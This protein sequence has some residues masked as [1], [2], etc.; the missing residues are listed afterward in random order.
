MT[1]QS[2]DAAC[3]PVCGSSASEALEPPHPT[4]SVT[5]GGIILDTPLRKIQCL[6]CGLARQ[7][8]L[9]DAVKAELYRDK[10]ALY[11]QRPGTSDSESARYAAMAEWILAEIAPAT[12]T[13]VLDIGCG[14]GF[15]LEALRRIHSSSEYDGVDPSVANSALARG[16]GFRVA[17]GFTPGTAPPRDKYDL[18]ITANVIS[19]IA[20]P[21]SF[22]SAL[23]SMTKPDGRLVI[24]SHNGREPGADLLWSD[25]EFSFCREHIGALASKVGLQL[26]EGR[27]IAPPRDQ[28]DKHVLVFQHNR[29]S[30]SVTLPSGAQRAKLLEGRHQYFQA[31]RQLAERLETRTRDAQGRVLNFG[32]SF[33]SML[34]AAY[35]PDYWGRVE[36]CV[37]DDGTGTFFGKPVISTAIVTNYSQ[38][39]IVLGVNPSSQATLAEHLSSHGEVV[40]WSDLITR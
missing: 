19:H 17:T 27:G 8:L 4:R 10:Y 16:R 40:M 12:P 37:V 38:P 15:L 14:G 25:V 32:A 35:C 18:V 39:L 13:T 5:S 29:S 2:S 9:P 34:L 23:A 21:L 3:C 24:F 31:W 36:A 30:T 11:H 7:R 28:S 33:W 1:D 6:E 22:L 20:D 26:L